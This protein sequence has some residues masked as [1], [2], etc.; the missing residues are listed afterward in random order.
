MKT[1]Y[2]VIGFGENRYGFF[3][4]KAV[5][6]TVGYACGIYNGMLWDP[7]YTGAVIIRQDHESWQV[8]LE[9]GTE[10][11]S[12]ECGPFMSFSVKKAPAL[13]MI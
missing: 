13:Q 10:N 5:S 9:F 8:I 7:D 11:M 4:Q 12:I 2:K 1:L 6:S 3:N